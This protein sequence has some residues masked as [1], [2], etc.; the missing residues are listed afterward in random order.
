M[1]IDVIKPGALSLFQDNGRYGFQKLG[2]PVCGPMDMN[3]H[4]LANLL[5]GNGNAAA[6]LEITLLGPTLRFTQAACIALTGADLNARL[7]GKPLAINRPHIV[8][9]DQVLSFAGAPSGI[10][11]YLAVHGGFTLQPVLD[12]CST[13]LKAQLGGL[14]GRALKAGDRIGLNTVLDSDASFLARCDR[15]LWD[16]KIY[17]PARLGLIKRNTARVIKG[18]HWPLFTADSIHAFLSHD[19]KISPQSDRMGYR[20]SGPKLSVEKPVQILSEA[21]AFGAMQVPHGGDPI[22]IMADRQTMG[23]YPKLAYIVSVDLPSLAQS[24]PGESLRFKLIS[25]EEAQQL[26]HR[27]DHAFSVLAASLATINSILTK[28]SA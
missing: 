15:L 18:P 12:S 6:T 2:V 3:A 9:A 1:S 27:R 25:L 20:I 11:A 16:M 21:T 13:Y 4:R 28:D 19:F 26:D 17:L 14:D 23:G 22:I 7:D 24:R 8:R 10:R 5:V